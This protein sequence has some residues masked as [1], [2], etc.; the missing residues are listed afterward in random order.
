MLVNRAATNWIK[1]KRGVRQGNPLSPYLFLLVAECLARMTEAAKTHNLIGGIG[2]K[3]SRVTLIQFAD[4]T[5]SFVKRRRNILKNIRFIWS[6]F[7][8]ASGLNAN[9]EKIKLFYMGDTLE[10]D[11]RLA[12]YLGCKGTLPTKYLGLPLSSNAPPK[13]DWIGIINKIRRRIDR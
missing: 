8:W 3:D 11:I 10:K 7:E 13:E 5:L 2:P 6:L 12:T 4:D 1:T 9:K